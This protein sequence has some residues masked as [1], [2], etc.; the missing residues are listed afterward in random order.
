MRKFVSKIMAA[1]NP[2]GNVNVIRQ[3]A[4]E[5]VNQRADA[6]AVVG[7][8]SAKNSSARGYGPIFKA[9]AEPH[10][11]AFYVPG[12][13]DVPFGDFLRE[14]A[15][16]E[17]VYPHLRGVHATCAIA[18]GYVVFSGM[19][20]AIHDDPATVRDEI[21]GLSYPGWEAE[22]RLKFLHELK[23]YQKVFMFATNPEH[24]GLG[25]KG[26]AVVAEIIN[27]YIPRIVLVAGE[28]RK[29]EIIGKSLVITLGNVDEGHFTMVDLRRHEV[30]DGQLNLAPAERRVESQG[31]KAA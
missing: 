5:A 25:E 6:I 30:I 28:P 18:P 24:K 9:L 11:P 2:K 27:T 22:Y 26:S 14:A 21:E 17:I 29:R 13:E 4:Q 10:L 3:L 16:V 23:D 31:P 8:L 7:N 12:P 1:A 19:G 15:N 20:G